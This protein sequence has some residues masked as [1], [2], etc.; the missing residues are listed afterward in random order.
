MDTKDIIAEVSAPLRGLPVF[1][2]G[3]LVAE[4]TYNL[5]NAHDDTD[6]FCSSEQSLF[7]S[8]ERLLNYGYVFD[9]KFDRVWHRW[10]RYGFKKWHTNSI[11]LTSPLN[12]EVNLVF[13]KQGGQP[14]S[15]LAQV[16]ESFDFGLLA[17]GYDL[18]S[19]LRRDMRSY[20]FPDYDLAGPL[21]LMPNKRADWLS[22]FFSQYNG[23]RESGRYAKYHQYGYDMSAVKDDLLTGYWAA[24]RY[25][26]GTGDADKQLLGQIYETTAI[27]I[28]GD[29]ID[30]LR[31]A[32]KE[33]PYL[34]ALDQIMETL[35]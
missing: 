3:S 4:E 13:K 8:V 22:G 24:A 27:L 34:T 1:L 21:P 28:E 18:E 19:G 29:S 33:I 9:D 15:T 11:K 23:L 5:V 26:A 35:E 17:V 32:G 14:T 12:N 6:I 16:L 10:V 2:A 30:K 25:Y 20:L 31:E 7:V